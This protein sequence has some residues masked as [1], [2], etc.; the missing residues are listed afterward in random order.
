MENLKLSFETNISGSHRQIVIELP[1]QNGEV[2]TNEFCPLEFISGKVK[3]LAALRGESLESFMHRCRTLLEA[4]DNLD[5]KTEI[6]SLVGAL[7]IVLMTKMNH[8]SQL[9][10][11]ELIADIDCFSLILKGIGISNEEITEIYKCVTNSILSL[12]HDKILI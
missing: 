9:P 3:L 8:K 4:V 6:D 12:Y 5:G 1:Y 10:F 2:A 11:V 7:M